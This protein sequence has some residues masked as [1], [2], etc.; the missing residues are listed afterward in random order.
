M[1]ML[2]ASSFASARWKPPSPTMETLSP[3]L[4]SVRVCARAPDWIRYLSAGTWPGRTPPG[5][6]FALLALLAIRTPRTACRTPRRV[7]M[8]GKV[9]TARRVWRVVRARSVAFRGARRSDRCAPTLVATVIA[10]HFAFAAAVKSR[11]RE[12]PL[13]ALMLACQWL[14]VLF[15]PLFLLG[16]ERMDP[17]DG[18][19]YGQSRLAP[20]WGRPLPGALAA[21]P[22]FS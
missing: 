11:E 13:W 7:A 1:R 17:I 9:R 22:P 8:W 2:S 20:D 18:G 5:C 3:V 19:G 16:V 6:F 21:P 4:P 10:G 14:D 15:V 12:V